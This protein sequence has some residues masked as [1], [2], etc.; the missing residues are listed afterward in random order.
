MRRLSR[1]RLAFMVGLPH[2]E[3]VLDDLTAERE[4]ALKAR[5]GPPLARLA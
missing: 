2:F 4:E 3:Y 5:P 1:V